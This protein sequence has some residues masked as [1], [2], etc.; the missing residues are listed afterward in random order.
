MHPPAGVAIEARDGV[1]PG[2]H[3]RSWIARYS[4]EIRVTQ[5]NRLACVAPTDTPQAPGGRWGLGRGVPGVRVADRHFASTLAAFRMGDQRAISA[6]TKAS[7]F[8][9]VRS[10]LPGS[11]PPR[12]D[13]RLRTPGSSSAWSS[14]SASLSMIVLRRALGRKNAGPDAHLIVDAGFLCRRDVG[15]D[16]QALLC[17]HGVGLDRAA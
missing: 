4:Y 9:G 7:N 13:R 5:A 11:D 1:H 6:F 8:A 16:R 3:V 2:Q 12:S 14:V 15:K 17:G 10:S